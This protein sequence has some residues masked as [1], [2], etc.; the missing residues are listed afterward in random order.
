M[1][2]KMVTEM[3]NYYSTCDLISVY[4]RSNINV[5][6]FEITWYGLIT[7]YMYYLIFVSV[8]V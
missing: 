3:L 1:A 2:S 8:R 6:L 7:V 5:P 4:E